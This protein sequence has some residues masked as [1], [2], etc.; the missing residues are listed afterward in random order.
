VRPAL[1]SHTRLTLRGPTVP[2][3]LLFAA[4][5]EYIGVA[6]LTPLSVCVRNGV[7]LRAIR[8]RPFSVSY[9]GEVGV[10]AHAPV[11]RLEKYNV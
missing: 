7:E 10:Q 9:S 6:P 1:L 5:G 4:A 2:G 11:C 3:L 8:R